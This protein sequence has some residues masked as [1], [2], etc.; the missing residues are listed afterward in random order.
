M[1]DEQHRAVEFAQGPFQRVAG[2]QVEMV[3]RLVEDQE[4]GVGGGQ[5]GQ[6]RA[7]A[8][9]AAQAAD[10]LKDHVAGD[11]EAGEQ[12]APLL[13][14]ELLVRGPHGIDHLHVRIEA[15]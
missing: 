1:A 9:A 15:R 2:P 4:V 6:R 12:V 13:L 10:F 14:D 7:V 8:L 5:P 11:A 3:R